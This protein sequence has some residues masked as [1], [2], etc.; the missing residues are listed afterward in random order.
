LA[1]HGGDIYRVGFELVLRRESA[2]PN[3]QWQADHT[4]LDV[5]VVD[6]AGKAARPWLTRDPGRPLP[7][8]RR[9]QV[10]LGAPTAAQTALAFRQ[11]VWR[12]ADP[13]W[14]V[15]GLPAALYSDHGAD[16]TGTHI[17]Q[18]CADLKVQLI[19]STPGRLGSVTCDPLT[20]S[21]AV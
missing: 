16:F 19:H 13:L 4:E 1:H 14:A 18:V 20:C 17:A 3:D 8:G 21:S 12:K 15:C 7:R 9:L 10:F 6:E 5:M 2:H 11:A